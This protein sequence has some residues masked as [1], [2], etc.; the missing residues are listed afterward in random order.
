VNKDATNRY[1][2]FN[3]QNQAVELHFNN[4]VVV[5]SSMGQ[6]EL[7]EDELATPQVQVLLRRRFITAHK[8]EH[9]LPVEAEVVAAGDDSSSSETSSDTDGKPSPHKGKRKQGGH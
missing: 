3:M 1:R 7:T 5:I 4:Q 6:V 9:E 2:V 8:M